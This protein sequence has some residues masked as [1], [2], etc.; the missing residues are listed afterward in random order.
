MSVGRWMASIVFADRIGLSRPRYTKQGLVAHAR[1]DI[2][3]KLF[4]RFGLI[5]SWLEFGNHFEGLIGKARDRQ[6]PFH[7]GAIDILKMTHFAASFLKLSH[8]SAISFSK[9]SIVPLLVNTTSAIA[10]RLL[11]GT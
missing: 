11:S 10:S 1:F 2:L 4:D 3:R 7:L 6:L 9:S 5:A 8:Q